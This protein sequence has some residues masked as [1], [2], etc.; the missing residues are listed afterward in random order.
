MSSVIAVI[1]ARSA[2]EAKRNLAENNFE[3]FEFSST[4]TT[5]D[6]ISGHP[7]IFMFQHK[8][9]ICIAPNSP[10][11][12]IL[13]LQNNQIPFSFGKHLVGKTFEQSVLYNCVCTDDFFFHKQKFTDE[14]ILKFVSKKITINLPQAFTA[15]SLIALSNNDFIT[16][17][18]GIEKVLLR[19]GFRCFFFNPSKIRIFGHKHGFIGGCCGIHNNTV[20]FNGN[21]ELHSDG[22]EMIRFI[23]NT[24][25]SVCYLHNDIL[26]DGG[27]IFLL[28]R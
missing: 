2:G 19:M 3:I 16:S 1:D 11:Q 4:G 15:C 10:E 21:P 26:Y 7:D 13:F 5:V 23:E 14:T 9:F 27:K 8:G 24:G 18:K 12:F 25:L 28:Q 17:D 22:T 6:S 20:Y